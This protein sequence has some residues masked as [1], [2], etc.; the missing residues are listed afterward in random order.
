MPWWR[1]QGDSITVEEEVKCGRDGGG[2]LGGR[3]VNRMQR[4]SSKKKKKSNPKFQVLPTPITPDTFYVLK[5][6]KQQNTSL[7]CWWDGISG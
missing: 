5:K 4:E 6:Q 1:Y 3:E 7:K 2:S